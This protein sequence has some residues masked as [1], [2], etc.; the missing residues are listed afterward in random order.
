[1][2]DVRQD[3]YPTI[4]R[5]LIRHEND[6]TN[7]SIMWLLVGQG[8]VINAYVSAKNEVAPTHAVLSLV[9]IL[10]SL[11]AFVKLYQ[12]Y[13]APG[14]L[15]LLGLQAKEGTLGEEHL[16]LTGWPKNRIK[17]WWRSVWLFPWFRQSRDL[18]EPWLVLPFL[19]SS[20][21]MAA[22][23]HTESSLH[24]GGALTVGVILSA[25]ILSMCCFVLV[26]SQS[27]DESPLRPESPNRPA[28]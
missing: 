4:I 12:S 24:I 1:M 21:W 20:M 14:Y 19:F 28:A 5:E 2:Y 22:L 6:V 7:H 9:G 17:G 10:V 25:V 16:P 11:S 27:K 23:L 15:Q 26:W 13:E 3:L 18:V 8:F